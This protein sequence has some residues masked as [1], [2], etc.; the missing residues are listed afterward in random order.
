MRDETYTIRVEGL[1][2]DL[3]ASFREGGGDLLLFLHGLGC[4]RSIFRHA[5]NH[6]GLLGTTLLAPDFPGFGDST[7]PCGYPATMES[8]AAAIDVLLDRFRDR[9]LHIVAHSMGGAVALLLSPGTLDTARSFLSVEGNLVGDDCGMVSREAAE[10][11]FEEYETVWFP[12]FRAQWSSHE[13]RYLALEKSD[14]MAFHRAAVSLVAWSDGGELLRRFRDL[15]KKATYVYGARNRDLRVLRHLKD[16]DTVEIP[17]AGH[18][19]MVDSPATFYT[20]VSLLTVHR[21]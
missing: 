17:Y 9:R 6:P 19:M 10:I 14:L 11:P 12:G 3:A 15:G 21:A 5:W 1:T 4:D 8:Y 2:F 7:L 18:F 13:G 16:R 20:Q